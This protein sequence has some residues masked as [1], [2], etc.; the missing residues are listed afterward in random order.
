MDEAAA[1]IRLSLRDAPAAE[2]VEALGHE[3]RATWGVQETELFLVD[4]RLAA[5]LPLHGR[6]MDA[7]AAWRCFDGQAPV[8]GD[9]AVYLPVTVR[10]ERLGVLKVAPPVPGRTAELETV[11][12]LLAHELSAARPTTD[13]YLAAA[14]TRRLTLAAEMQWELLPGRS[15]ATEQFSLAGQLEPAYAVRG[16]TFDWAVN[17]DRLVVTIMDG[18]GEG[19]KA[20][21]LSTLATCALRNARRG[22]VELADQAS[23]TDDAIFAE[24]R[25]SQYVAVLLLEVD[26]R[27]GLMSTVDAGSPQLLLLRA[28]EITAVEL[29]RHDPL[30]MF[31]GSRYSRREFQLQP[32]DRL[33]LI[34]DGVHGATIGERRYGETDLL[35]FI[36]RSR[37][38]SALDVVRTLVNE[39]RAFVSGEL[40]D[41]AAVVC[42]DWFGPTAPAAMG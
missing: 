35:R 11:A 25:G 40:A 42:L 6:P 23:L 29:D 32:S 12:E 30:G 24:H 41:D 13:R 15:C 14:R 22:G 8:P 28:G 2:I 7:A 37:T 3:L 34:S 38:M 39:L 19:V 31:E 21:A 18:M 1:R 10:G 20:A 4:Y 17:P 9:E 27:T 16:D 26:L 33:I 36:R 5:L